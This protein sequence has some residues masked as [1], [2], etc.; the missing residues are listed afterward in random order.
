MRWDELK[1]AAG[2]AVQ[3]QANPNSPCTDA[4]FN[5]AESACCS[6]KQEMCA[7]VYTRDTTRLSAT[8]SGLGAEGGDPIPCKS[9]CAL[10]DDFSGTNPTCCVLA[11]QPVAQMCAEGAGDGTTLKCDEA[12]V[13]CRSTP[14]PGDK[15]DLFLARAVCT[16]DDFSGDEGNEQRLTSAI[17]DPTS[18]EAK[19][20]LQKLLPLLTHPS[21]CVKAN[22]CDG[23][24]F[25]K[26][27][28]RAA[29]ARVR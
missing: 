28:S 27:R 4:D 20:L 26:Q 3:K 7:D 8:Q 11:K 24:R 5:G 1:D 2:D 16:A 25:A 9:E 23:G 10:K 19:D 22:T 15:G 12:M 21:C 18:A 13:G 17:K 14:E 6:K 29:T